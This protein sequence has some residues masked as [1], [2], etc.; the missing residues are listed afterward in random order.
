MYQVL[1]IKYLSKL[2]SFAA[3]LIILTTA[4]CILYTSTAEASA[5]DLGINPPI[6]QIEAKPPASITTPLT[7]ENFGEDPVTLKVYFKLF[8]AN[9][10]ENGH[11][12]Y[13]TPNDPF[14]GANPQIF[15]YMQLVE[16]DHIKDTITLSPG[17][18]KTLGFHI[19]I[20]KDEPFSD[21]YFSLVFAS[22]PSKE[23][24]ISQSGSQTPAGIAMNVLLS[25]GPK[26]KAKASIQEFSAPFFLEKGPVPFTVRI[27]NIGGH[28]IAPKGNIMIQNMFGQ[29]IG[30]VDL[31]PVNILADTVR[32]LPDTAKNPDSSAS[33]TVTFVSQ[34]YPTKAVWPETFLLGPY[35]ATLTILVSDQGP[36][37]RKTIV[38]FA[39]PLQVTLAVT[40]SVI[41]IF[42]LIKKIRQKRQS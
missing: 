9:T 40:A 26:G 18:K 33:S 34:S 4:Y 35:S 2:C 30:R 39:L 6:L 23:V 42:L 11:I 8:T 28:V 5:V 22:T 41:V 14:P 3:F 31:L 32:A 7:I 17:Q 1:R 21:Y 38:F 29:L 10:G 16:N 25:V 19:G 37:Y 13:L 24:E 36:I 15:S 12:R 20:P 27:R